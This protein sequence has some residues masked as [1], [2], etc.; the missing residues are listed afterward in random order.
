MAVLETS[1]IRTL[2]YSELY[3][4]RGQ[5]KIEELKPEN[6]A[7]P[8]GRLILVTSAMGVG[9]SEY[10]IRLINYCLDSNINQIGFKAIEDKRYPP[11]EDIG[12][13]NG[14]HAPAV[15]L[16][17][18]EQLPDEYCKRRHVYG[19]IAVAVID[20]P[21]IIGSKPEDTPEEI[22]QR[23]LK[24]AAT[25]E[26]M[27]GR[28]TNVVITTLDTNFLKEEFAIYSVLSQ[29]PAAEIFKILGDCDNCGQPDAQWTQ[30]LYLGQPASRYSPLIE[31]AGSEQNLRKYSY[32]KRGSDCHV[33]P[34]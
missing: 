15:P 22:S 11:F 33:I 3:D 24:L 26:V 10:G 29:N 13:R 34:D 1:P 12:S 28:N 9:K 18:V 17:C 14:M 4:E 20:E 7:D 32:Q 27:R 2:H 6:L 21:F 5:I 8:Q 23:A 16:S 19:E 25:C 30:R 31:V